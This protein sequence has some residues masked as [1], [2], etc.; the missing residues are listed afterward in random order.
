MTLGCLP[1]LAVTQDCP[2]LYEGWT[3]L[4]QH[5]QEPQECRTAAFR[6]SHWGDTPFMECPLV[7]ATGLRVGSW[8][9]LG[10]WTVFCHGSRPE[11]ASLRPC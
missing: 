8:P 9:A 2:Y 6:A 3:K 7:Q 4:H 1:G 11:A 10:A 5:L